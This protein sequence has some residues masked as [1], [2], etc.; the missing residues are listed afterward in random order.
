[1]QI[2]D[3]CLQPMEIKRSRLQCGISQGVGWGLRLRR[4]VYTCKEMV[5]TPAYLKHSVNHLQYYKKA[6]TGAELDYKIFIVWPTS[7][8][9]G[10]H[11]RNRNSIDE[12]DALWYET[13]MNVTHLGSEQAK[14]GNSISW[15][16]P[17]NLSFKQHTPTCLRASS[18]PKLCAFEARHPRRF[19][20][21]HA[22]G[23]SFCPNPF[24]MSGLLSCGRGHVTMF[25]QCFPMVLPELFNVIVPPT[26]HVRLLTLLKIAPRWQ[27]LE[28]CHCEAFRARP[29]DE[30]KAMFRRRPET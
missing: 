29:C 11:P 14:H 16:S 5:A 25:F 7:F 23:C 30:W 9:L 15:R 18:V 28:G 2:P 20:R 6:K 1:M 4:C 21:Y 8:I 3:L 26:Q 24:I 10:P 27:V 17:P 13:Y 19:F 22:G 12:C